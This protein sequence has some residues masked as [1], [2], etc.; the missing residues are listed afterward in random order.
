ME[1]PS[2]RFTALVEGDFVVFL[3]GMRIN[4]WWRPDQWLPVAFAMA[5]MQAE[6]ARTPDLGLLGGINPGFSNPSVSIQYWRSA[7]HLFRYATSKDAAHLPAWV[8]FRERV[9][10]SRA[11]G[12]WHET[13]LVSAGRYEAV[14]ADMPPFGLGTFAPLVPAHGR[15]D[16]ARGRVDANTSGG[17]GRGA[18]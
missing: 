4:Q 14:Y 15:R 9:K 10:N 7:E 5:R 1:S 3:I 11:V 2:R 6:L 18:P 16:G 13:F 8:A 17:D 12:I